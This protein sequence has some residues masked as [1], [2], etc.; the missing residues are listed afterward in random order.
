MN[1][2]VTTIVLMLAQAMLVHSN[3]ITPF[4][5]DRYLG[6]GDIP[7]GAYLNYPND[8]AVDSGNNLVYIADTNNNF[9]RVVNRTSNTISTIAG[10][11]Y[12]GSSGDGKY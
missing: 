8:V 3:I 6:D 11:G 10:T 1:L 4:A 12:A 2:R 9:I 5:G 7:T